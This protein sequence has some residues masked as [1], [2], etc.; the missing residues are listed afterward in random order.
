MKNWDIKSLLTCEDVREE[1]GNKVTIVGVFS[2]I[3]V[4]SL[5]AVIRLAL[6]VEFI[7]SKIGMYNFSIRIDTPTIEKAAII[8]LEIDVETCASAVSTSVPKF[9]LKINESGYISIFIKEKSQKTWT[10]YRKVH[11]EQGKTI[12]PMVSFNWKEK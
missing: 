2:D 3:V 11:V 6:W 4:S 9:P 8:A 1:V 12:G 10:L 5:P 7:V